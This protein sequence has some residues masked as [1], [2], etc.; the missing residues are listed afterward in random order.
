MADTSR[1]H[2]SQSRSTSA[3]AKRTGR[4]FAR[5]A[6]RTTKTRKPGR[7]LPGVG[8]RGIFPPLFAYSFV[9]FLAIDEKCNH[10]KTGL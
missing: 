6:K 5:A 1:F 4:A 9:A 10:S 8:R 7:R 2:A 3:M